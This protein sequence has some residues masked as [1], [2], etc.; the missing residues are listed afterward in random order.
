MK[1]NY[2]IISLVFSFFLLM[3]FSLLQTDNGLKRKW[4]LVEFQKFTKEELTKNNAYI[5][6]TKI[7]KGGNAKMGCNYI[8]F[9]VKVKKSQKIAISNVGSTAMY[10]ENMALEAEFSNFL[11]SVNE[12]KITG[13]YLILK[14]TK[15]ETMKFIAED[16][17]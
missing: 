8:F 13:H 17:D 2:L 3:N 12:Y 9:N 10:C 15:G 1:T 4:Q 5:D 7:E 6:L 16:W 14:N 11:P